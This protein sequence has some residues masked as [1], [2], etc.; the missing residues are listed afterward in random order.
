MSWTIRRKVDAIEVRCPARLRIAESAQ[1]VRSFIELMRT[2]RE[3]PA[4]VIDIRGL[5]EYDQE[6]RQAWQVAIRTHRQNLSCLIFISDNPVFRMVGAG[7]GLATGLRTTF[8][9]DD[10]AAELAIARQNLRTGGPK[11]VA[12]PP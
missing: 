12:A 8:V 11:R 6:T 5:C 2:C 9:P 3:Q 10:Q 7:V 1:A 4:L